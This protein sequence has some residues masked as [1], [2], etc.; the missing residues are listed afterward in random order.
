I[1]RIAFSIRSERGDATADQRQWIGLALLGVWWGAM[2]VATPLYFPYLRL[3]LPYMLAAWLAAALTCGAT[4]TCR[5]EK[6]DTSA[7]RRWKRFVMCGY[8][9][10]VLLTILL[11]WRPHRRMPKLPA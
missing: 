4:A 8:V 1:F 9:A 5:D 3:A 10:A 2:L 7:D 11:V 6:H